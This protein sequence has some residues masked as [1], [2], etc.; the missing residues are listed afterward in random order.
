MNMKEESSQ[1]KKTS[2]IPFK[3]INDEN[4][5]KLG[6]LKVVPRLVTGLMTGGPFMSFEVSS[7]AIQ[8]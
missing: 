1:I 4:H 5:V 3:F 2:W 6:Y 8:R 7:W